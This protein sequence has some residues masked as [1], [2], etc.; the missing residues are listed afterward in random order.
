M[1]NKG[2]P[3]AL[4]KEQTGSSNCNVKNNTKHPFK[5]ETVLDWMI[6]QSEQGNKVT[7]FDAE[8]VGDHCFNTTVSEISRL[9]GVRISRESTTRPTR[10]KRL[11]T[12]N[13][14]WIEKDD[15]AVARR[16]LEVIRKRRAA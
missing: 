6:E 3:A 2:N 9:D 4:C 13:E 15:L 16:A 1:D 14:Y 10:F 5:R 11:V 8:L 7:R 12:C